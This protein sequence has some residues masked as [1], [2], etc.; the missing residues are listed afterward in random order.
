MLCLFGI[1]GAAN[2]QDD[3]PDGSVKLVKGKLTPEER[4]LFASL[5]MRLN[6]KF[7]WSPFVERVYKVSETAKDELLYTRMLFVRDDDGYVEHKYNFYEVDFEG[8]GVDNLTD[9]DIRY[10]YSLGTGGTGDGNIRIWG[11]ETFITEN[12]CD[13]S[14]CITTSL[15]NGKEV[16][17]KVLPLKQN[18]A[19]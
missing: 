5:T 1:T 3:K 4:T 18:T 8:A 13:M 9:F 10:T 17:K 16:Y 11:S 19:N 12:V 14:S 15:V 6:K 7:T 2:A